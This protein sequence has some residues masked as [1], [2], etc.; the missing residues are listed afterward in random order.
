MALEAFTVPELLRCPLEEIV[1]QVILPTPPSHILL[2]QFII[3]PPLSYYTNKS[4]IPG[5]N[6]VV[7]YVQHGMYDAGRA[8]ERLPANGVFGFSSSAAGPEQCPRRLGPPRGPAGQCSL[9]GPSMGPQ[10]SLNVPR[11]GPQCS[12]NGPSMFPERALNI[13]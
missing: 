6:W 13:P 4:M 12:L 11:M 10:C 8:D 5:D 2:D 9:N 1:L 3:Q 7:P